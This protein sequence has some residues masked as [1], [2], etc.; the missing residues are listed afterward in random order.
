MVPSFLKLTV[1]AAVVALAAAHCPPYW[2][3]YMDSCFQ[4]FNRPSTW[5]EAEQYCMGFSTCEG[6]QVGHLASIGDVGTNG[7]ITKYKRLIE[8]Q[9]PV[10]VWIGLN[11]QTFEGNFEWS[12][13]ANVTFTHWER[14]QPNNAQ[15]QENC[16]TLTGVSS[17]DPSRWD[18]ANCLQQMAFVCELP[19]IDPRAQHQIW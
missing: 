7:F 4:I 19:G 13:G 18:D 5:E 2:T 12:N 14:G 10:R 9:G 8:A 1:L 16:V 17:S 6:N 11:D 15:G 3:A